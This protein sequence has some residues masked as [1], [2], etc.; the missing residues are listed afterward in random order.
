MGDIMKITDE[1]FACLVRY[2][3]EGGKL[4]NDGIYGP[5]TRHEL[6]SYY[7]L[8]K[9]KL[10]EAW[11]IAKSRVG[12][13]GNPGTNNVSDWIRHL[14]EYCNFPVDA[15][16]PWCAIFASYCLNMA[17]ID[18][19]SRGAYRLCEKLANTN[20]Y[21]EYK[22]EDM[23]VGKVYLCCWRRSRW[24]THREAHVRLVTPKRVQGHDWATEFEYIAGNERPD[25]VVQGKLA[26]RQFTNKLIMVVGRV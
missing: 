2:F 6:R 26:P 1:E 19:K 24:N 13:G 15:N 20:G 8:D 17:R 4:D 7:E 14:R 23:E 10:Q 18:V 21:K 9:S 25:N 5:K 11:N 3:Q 22:T 12:L 16:G